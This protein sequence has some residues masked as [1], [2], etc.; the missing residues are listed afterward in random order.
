MLHFGAISSPGASHVTA[1]TA[2]GRELRQRGHRFTIF[3]I[4][5]IE[6]LAL[7]ED[8]EFCPLGAADYPKGSLRTYG[9][10]LSKTK[11]IRSLRLG[12]AK[13]IA[14]IEMLLREAPDAMR[15]RGITA[16]LVD[17][18]QP[19]GSTLAEQLGIPFVTICN[20]VAAVPDPSV[21]PAHT[22][23]Q[24]SCHWLPRLRNRAVY[25]A[26]EIGL[27]PLLRTVNRTRKQYGFKPLRRY[28]DSWSP[29]AVISQQTAEFDFPNRSLPRQFHYI[30]LLRR[31]G[32]APVPFPFDRLDGRPLVYATLGTIL[33]DNQGVHRKLS[34]VCKEMD[35]QLAIT[36]GGQGNPSDYDSLPGLPVV[37]RN[38]PQ[39]AVLERTAITFCHGG[40]NTVLESLAAGVPVLAMPVWADQFGSAARLTRSGAGEM[41]SS[42]PSRERL[43]QCLK[44]LL[45]EPRYRERAQVM[46]Q[47]IETANGE[48][49]AA[50]IIEDVLGKPGASIR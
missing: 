1:M 24:Y 16:L 30:G 49:R 50:D 13:A 21:P 26:F 12:V 18:M 48:R 5:D 3:N 47:S 20:A 39:L 41:I 40:N 31:T 15:S 46:Q 4:P 14:E 32:S 11:G 9:E 29:W 36:L 2:I 43:Y 37:V 7:S 8:S 22:P 34:E 35:V 44:L 33:L 10:Q 42:P 25:L 23:W 17:Q 6:S 28:S 19:A 27:A 38:A 45:T